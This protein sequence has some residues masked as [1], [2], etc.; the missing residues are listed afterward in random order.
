MNEDNTFSEVH[1][2]GNRFYRLLPQLIAFAL[3]SIGALCWSYFFWNP[4]FIPPDALIIQTFGHND[5]A[6]QALKSANLPMMKMVDTTTIHRVS[7]FHQAVFTTR[8]LAIVFIL[9][10]FV[11]VFLKR[12]F[13]GKNK[14]P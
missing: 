11:L 8:Y 6:L 1:R 9:Y 14:T 13:Y 4:N 7:L 10:F 3:T 2:G 5:K 12:L